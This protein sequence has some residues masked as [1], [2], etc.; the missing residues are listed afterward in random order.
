M[1]R[2]KKPT[3]WV[4]SEDSHTSF[5]IW[6]LKRPHMMGSL[7]LRGLFHHATDCSLV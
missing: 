7:R 6:P 2:Y 1:V 4:E 5:P 3:T